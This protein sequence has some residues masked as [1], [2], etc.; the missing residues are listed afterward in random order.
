MKSTQTRGITGG[1][2]PKYI[3][4]PASGRKKG[5]GF[6]EFN[7]YDP[8]DKLVLTVSHDTCKVF[9]GSTSLIPLDLSGSYFSLV[10]RKRGGEIS[11]IKLF[12]PKKKVI[13]HEL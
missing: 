10:S 9:N 8:V 12:N 11:Q 5:F 13:L 7:D 1:V 4:L 6:V 2:W 3:N